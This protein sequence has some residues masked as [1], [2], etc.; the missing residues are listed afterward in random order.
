MI[1]AQRIVA[2]AMT[3]VLE[4]QELTVAIV[5]HYLWQKTTL[6]TM[7][8]E[9][10]VRCVVFGFLNIISSCFIENQS[11]IP[12]GSHSCLFVNISAGQ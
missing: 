7:L 6:I 10:T 11:A 3:I 2:D 8:E 4:T 9:L 12:N 1:E 5:T